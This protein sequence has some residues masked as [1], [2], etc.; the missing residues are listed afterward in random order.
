[1][2]KHK[3]G[4]VKGNNT[5]G[6]YTKVHINKVNHIHYCYD[7]ISYIIIHYNIMKT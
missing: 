4:L 1:M 3:N 2:L 5:N 7:K 6:K